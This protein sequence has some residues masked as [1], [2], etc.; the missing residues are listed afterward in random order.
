MNVRDSIQKQWQDASFNDNF[1]FSKT[2][3]LF[4]DICKQIIELILNIK[5]NK[6]FY[7]EREKI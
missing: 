1:I 2:L 4:P 7:P 5:V 6:I 3:E